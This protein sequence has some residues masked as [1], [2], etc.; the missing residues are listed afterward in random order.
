MFNLAYADIIM[1]LKTSGE[2]RSAEWFSHHIHSYRSL[3]LQDKKNLKVFLS[4]DPQIIVLDAA[5]KEKYRRV[6]LYRHRKYGKPDAIKGY[7]Y[8]LVAP[9]NKR[10]PVCGKN[11][12]KMD[13]YA[14]ARSR[15]LLST[16]CKS[17]Y[18]SRHFEQRV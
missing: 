10:C 17:C 5:S 1:E 14:N 13:F 4:G 6:R 8:P 2:C 18:G 11:K 3:S 7:I 9:A 16:Y 15:D 12:A